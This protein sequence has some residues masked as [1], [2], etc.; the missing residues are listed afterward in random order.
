MH[1]EGQARAGISS[2][3]IHGAAA[4]VRV[5]E[6]NEMMSFCEEDQRYEILRECCE[7]KVL[8]HPIN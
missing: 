2:N 3:M 5:F 8:N 7:L 6:G 1:A 4:G